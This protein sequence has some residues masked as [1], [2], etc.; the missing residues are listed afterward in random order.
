MAVLVG[1]SGEPMK[2][3]F[4]L[5]QTKRFT[6]ESHHSLKPSR[7]TTLLC[8]LC[9]SSTPHFPSSR[10][11]EFF[12]QLEDDFHLEVAEARRGEP[13][14]TSKDLGTESTSG[15][16]AAQRDVYLLLGVRRGN[17][18]EQDRHSPHEKWRRAR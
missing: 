5:I 10:E 17:R 8:F 2:K 1:F 9:F 15:A 14:S 18:P 4:D 7:K 13:L 6:Q 12:E 3:N 11:K 16:I